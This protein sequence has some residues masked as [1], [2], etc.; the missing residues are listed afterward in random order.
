MR[1]DVQIINPSQKWF[2]WSGSTGILSYYDKE[3]KENIEVETPFT[4][5]LLDTFTTIKG[6]NEDSKQGIFSNEV[7]DTTKQILTVRCGKD[8]IAKGLYQEIKKDVITAGGGYAQSCYI[9]YKEG[10]ELVIGNITMS[11]SSF[12]GGTH[13]PADKNMKDVEIGGWLA[14]SKANAANLYKKGVVLQGKDERICT[15]GSVKFYA[16]SFKLVDVTP[17]TDAKAIELTQTLKAFMTEYFKKTQGQAQ[18]EQV[19]KQVE[20]SHAR[21]HGD[22]QEGYTE[23]EKTFLGVKDEPETPFVHDDDLGLPF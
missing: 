12:S 21:I 13:K 11:G 2:S 15:N 18:E 5:L 3:K 17:E 23:M 9:A 19:A 22:A 10:G 20:E 8:L 1:G 6:Y 16:P 4:F 7:K 14:F